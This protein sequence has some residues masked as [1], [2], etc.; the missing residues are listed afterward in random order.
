MLRVCFDPSRSGIGDMVML[1]WIAQGANESGSAIVRFKH[2]G[3]DGMV[4]MLGQRFDSKRTKHAFTFGTGSHS[5]DAEMATPRDGMLPRVRL[6]QR[7]LPFPTTSVARPP[8]V[9]PEESKRF[10]EGVFTSM[11]NP[12]PI[13]LLFPYGH[14]KNR[15]WPYHKWHRLAYHLE[16][17]GYNTLALHEDK[18]GIDNM[19]HW[20]YG[21]PLEDV[22]ALIQR[23]DLVVANDSGM[24]HL[25][26]TI[27]TQTLAIMGPTKPEVV[28][29]HYLYAAERTSG[30][31]PFEF[32]TCKPK[33]C[34]CVGCHYE[35]DPDLIG[36]WK[37]CDYGCAAMD[38]LPEIDVLSRVTD[39]MEREPGMNGVRAVERALG[40]GSL[41]CKADLSRLAH[42]ARLA[43]PESRGQATA[44]EFGTHTGAT[45]VLLAEMGYM[46]ATLDD[47]SGRWTHKGA[48]PTKSY[49]DDL[50]AQIGSYMSSGM[51]LPYQ[52]DT[53]YVDRV[54]GLLGVL[55]FDLIWIDGNH[56]VD[57]VLANLEVAERH[58]KPG[59]IICG[60]GLHTTKGVPAA[61]EKWFERIAGDGIRLNPSDWKTNKSGS[62]VWW[63]R[64]PTKTEPSSVAGCSIP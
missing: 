60:H 8:I 27:G 28:Y 46:V 61:L 14:Q 23:A 21:F 48:K 37:A 36:H 4:R 32:I 5:Y 54:E 42:T 6:W 24:A 44:L 38:A 52:L 29:G 2:S 43:M 12:G 56:S 30:P 10:A 39:M 49:K 11:T 50:I 18:D 58:V 26:P 33:L 62:N 51:I 47:Y 17:M 59:G 40:C 22:A 20:L 35:H 45:A 31:V 19:P 63:L 41:T 16:S 9:I 15:S 7:Q 64:W 25:G 53:S 55:M 1:A 34:P 3:F 57:A 13:V